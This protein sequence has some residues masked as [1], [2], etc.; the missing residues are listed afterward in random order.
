MRSRSSVALTTVL[1]A[2]L[3]PGVIADVPEPLETIV[4]GDEKRDS[5]ETEVNGMAFEALAAFSEFPYLLWP[6]DAEN[7]VDFPDDP[8]GAAAWLNRAAETPG[9]SGCIATCQEKTTWRENA[10]WQFELSRRGLFL[11][12]ARLEVHRSDDGR[13]LGIVIHAPRPIRAIEDPALVPNDEEWVYY[14]MQNDD[15]SVDIVAARVVREPRAAGT[16]LT[17]AAGSDTLARIIEPPQQFEVI[18]PSLAIFEE[19][20]VP[21]G[22]FP[23][24][25]SV[26]ENGTVWLSQP[27]DN[28]ITSFDPGTQTF[29]FNPTSGGSGPDGLIVGT[30]GRVW[31]GMYNSGSLGLWDSVADVFHNFP[32]PYANAAMAIPVETSDGH[33]WVTDHERNRI[34]EF[35][36]ENE[37]WVRSLIVPSNGAW[38]VQGYE[39]RER[40]EVYFTEYSANRLAKVAL[41]GDTIT[42]IITPG[43]GPAF[44]VYHDDKVYYSRWNEAGIGVYDVDTG[45]IT[46]YEFPINNES[47]GPMWIAPNGHVVTGTRNRGYIMVFNPRT[48]SFAAYLIPTSSPGLKDGLTVDRQ[49]VIWFTETGV[50]K[51]GRLILMP[52]SP[53]SISG[54]DG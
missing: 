6:R 1:L 40:G 30:G 39:D 15:R 16:A 31:S 29:K 20:D 23:D 43:G 33:V 24:Q 51:L 4:F 49:G 7:A 35:D 3:A 17:I 5:F 34:S 48:E 13:F 54:S 38:I 8:D 45:Q 26:D 12:G 19:Y 18:D 53:K 14:P 10:V 47:G 9:Y 36:P 37:S 32:A 21:T 11:H 22:T 28:F 50:D 41:G 52:L 42:E 27:L 2:I 46:E 44:C 25:I